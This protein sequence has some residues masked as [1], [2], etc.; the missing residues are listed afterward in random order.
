MLSWVGG[1]FRGVLMEVLD[2][3]KYVY[4]P[5]HLEA[6]V[7]MT[8]KSHPPFLADKSDCSHSGA[9]EIC[10]LSIIDIWAHYDGNIVFFVW[11]HY[12][13]NIVLFIFNEEIY[14]QE[15]KKI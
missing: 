7:Q 13:G 14:F 12:D 10:E 3:F 11:A 4:N 15:I 6:L 1:T 5:V 2:L 9:S 8:L